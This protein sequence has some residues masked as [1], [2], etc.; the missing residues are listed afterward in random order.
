MKYFITL[1]VIAMS[2]M[3]IVTSCTSSKENKIEQTWKLLDISQALPENVS[4]LWEFKGGKFYAF[5]Q[6]NDTVILTDS[7]DSGWYQV[8]GGLSSSSVSIQGCSIA[9]FNDDWEIKK[10]KKDAM[11]LMGTKDNSFVYKEF[12]NFPK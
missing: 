4:E 12:V 11:I 9:R 10:L 1:V 3:F 7:V 2:A 6:T 8:K 5:H